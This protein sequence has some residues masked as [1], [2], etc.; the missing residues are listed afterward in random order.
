MISKDEFLTAFELWMLKQFG[1][2][3]DTMENL[4]IHSI[5]D[6]WLDDDLEYCTTCTMWNLYD[7]AKAQLKGV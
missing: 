7:K 6:G 2:N 1:Y 4:R 5:V 3:A